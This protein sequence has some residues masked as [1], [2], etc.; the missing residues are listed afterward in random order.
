MIENFAELAVHDQS[1]RGLSTTI[2]ILDD[3]CAKQ[4][5]HQC[6]GQS[7]LP[8]KF[9]TIYIY[10]WYLLVIQILPSQAIATF[11]EW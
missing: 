5:I 1:T 3:Y 8:P 11:S 7:F 4:P 2:F 9:S 6:F 10:I